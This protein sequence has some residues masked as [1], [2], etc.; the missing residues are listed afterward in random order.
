MATHRHRSPTIT[1]AP[2]ADR[3][4]TAARVRALGVIT[5]LTTA[6]SSSGSADPRPTA[7]PRPTPFQSR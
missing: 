1:H 7:L 4:W 2:A 5:T 6:A 3:T